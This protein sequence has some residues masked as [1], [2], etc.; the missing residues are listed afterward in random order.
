MTM[1]DFRDNLLK[2]LFAEKKLEEEDA[3]KL[4][5]MSREE[6]IEN[7]LL[8]INITIISHVDDIYELNVPDNFSKLR[9]GDKVI[10][11][12]DSSSS[13]SEATIIDVYFDTLTISCDKELDINATFSI[14]QKSP[15]LLQTL[16]SCLEGIYSGVPGAAFLRLLSG[17]E[18]LKPLIS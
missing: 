17:E 5:I 6:K 13:G 16:I 1:E 9:T 10:I 3:E 18:S 8:L 14:E 2:Y 12:E 15:D 4:K 11:A 7:N